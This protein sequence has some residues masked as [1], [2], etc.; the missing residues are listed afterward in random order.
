[1]RI[2]EK[3]YERR[4]K[5]YWLKLKIIRAKVEWRIGKMLPL[6]DKKFPVVWWGVDGVSNKIVM[7]IHRFI[8]R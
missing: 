5:T 1:M 7:L 3:T 6:I 8:G 2:L 4:E